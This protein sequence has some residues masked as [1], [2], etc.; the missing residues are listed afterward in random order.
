MTKRSLVFVSLLF[1]LTAATA[2]AQ[3]FGAVLT[4]S[5]ETPPTT[6]NGFGNAT[7][8][9]DPTHTSITVNVTVSGLTTPIILAH[10]HKGAFGVAG[11]VVIDFSA[12]TNFANGKLSKTF[13]IDK[14][15]GDDIAANPT[16]YYVNVHTTQNPGGEIRGQL[17]LIGDATLLFAE[18]RGSNEVPATG[19]ASVGS[20]LVT[21]DNNNVF[22]FEV[23][24][25]GL[26]NPTL[27]HIHKAVAGVNGSVVVNFALSTSAFSNGRTK[28]TIQ[29]D[30]TLAADIKANPANY[31]VNVHSTAFPGGEIRGQLANAIENDIAVA[32]N[33]TTG[34]GDKFVTDVRIFNP[35]FASP[36]VAL[37][38]Y[39][40]SGSGGNTNA[41]ASQTVVI[42]ARGESVLDD[43]T[44][45]NGLNSVGSIG[46]IRV[47]SQNQLAVTSNIFNDQRSAN[48]G[49]FGQFVPSIARSSELRRGVVPHLSNKNRD[50]TNPSGFRTNIGF[51]NPNQSSVFVRLE[52]RDTAGNLL[53]T[54]TITLAPLSQQQNAIGG[55]FPGVDLSNASCTLSFDASAPIIVYGAVNDNVSGDSIFV[56][57]QPDPGVAASQL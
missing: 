50:V 5:Q 3:T 30:P 9:L 57:A 20:A 7:V 54:S 21:I 39:L 28:G 6:S 47:T 11:G 10:I 22:T 37:V 8:T 53:G 52:L 4:P 41:T 16:N 32:G 2:N 56:V 24:I 36:A 48:K 43:V 18:L 27:S 14:T 46:A 12:P 15:L 26:Q 1:I 29:V 55:Y 49:T 19:S 33:V 42:P 51:F 38:E 44:G 23:N 31:Y 34:A 13:A 40:V 25:D 45:P 35:S 17:T